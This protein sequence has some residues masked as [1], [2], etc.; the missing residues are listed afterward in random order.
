MDSDRT[1]TLAKVQIFDFL[2]VRDT[3][4]RKG[5]CSNKTQEQKVVDWADCSCRACTTV[6]L[7][8]CRPSVDGRHLE[9]ADLMPAIR[10][11]GQK[12]FDAIAFYD[13]EVVKKMGPRI[14]VL[15]THNLNKA[16]DKAYQQQQMR[17]PMRWFNRGPYC[18]VS[19]PCREKSPEY[20]EDSEPESHPPSDTEEDAIETFASEDEVDKND[21]KVEDVLVEFHDNK[22]V[23]S[24]EQEETVKKEKEHDTKEARMQRRQRRQRRKEEEDAKEE[25]EAKETEEKEAEEG[26][27]KSRK[28]LSPARSLPPSSSPRCSAA[29]CPLA[30]LHRC[31]RCLAVSFCSVACSAAAWPGHR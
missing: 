16:V 11:I 10:L 29:G 2:A 1:S 25:E 18:P 7:N 22:Q 9:W 24:P 13:K 5:P 14:Q 21:Q 12:E 28:K 23:N 15:A 3:L 26:R 30:G 17:C 20:P 6:K 19:R 8:E 27:R 31:S 4:A